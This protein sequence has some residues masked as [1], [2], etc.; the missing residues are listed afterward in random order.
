MKLISCYVENFGKLHE[1]RHT[2]GDG[3]NILLEDNGWGKTTFAA[4]LKAMFYGL[5]YTTKKSIAENERKHYMPWQGGNFGGYVIFEV[6]GRKYRVER[7]FGAKD[8]DDTFALYNEDSGLSCN[9]YSEH[10][11]EDLF[12]LDMEAFERS[13]YIPQQTS[14]TAINDSLAARLSNSSENSKEPESYQGAV[15]RLDE[16]I[17]YYKKKGDNGRISELEKSIADITHSLDQ[18]ENRTESVEQLKNRK[19]ELETKR[20][21]LFNELKE[22]RDDIKKASEYDGL[23]A[24]KSHY[25]ML[26]KNHL[27]SKSQFDACGLFFEKPELMEELNNKKDELD[28]VTELETKYRDESE[29]LK[30]LE[31]RKH[32]LTSQYAASRRTP[33]SSVILLL[34]GLLA[35]GGA[36]F[37]WV[38]NF[39]F[40]VAVGVATFGILLCV[41]GLVTWIVGGNRIKREFRGKIE[42]V[43]E[44]IDLSRITL[45]EI[46][47]NKERAQKNLENYL[48]GFQVEDPDNI[49]KSIA[50]IEAKIREYKRLKSMTDNANIELANFEAENDMDKI[51]G[52][53]VPKY[54]LGELQKREA[55]TNNALVSVMEEKNAVV[56]RMDALMNEDEDESDLLQAKENLEQQLQDA[57]QRYEILSMT[58]EFL[59]TA[60]ERFK[61]KYIQKMKKAFADYTGVL[62]GT[63]MEEASVDVDLNV[64]LEEFGTK[65]G[66]E[67]YSAGSQDMLS[68]AARFSLVEAMFEEE[69]PFLILD[70]P[71]VNLDGKRLENAMKFLGDIAKKYQILYFTCHDSRG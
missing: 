27:E 69:K 6:S 8:K 55:G 64:T 61:T 39:E 49:L 68:L 20:I 1:Y 12:G 30:E 15:D 53:A 58:K 48:R 34:L 43:D 22:I 18:Y 9:D 70:D 24:R 57:N 45:R 13:T 47:L 62:N 54:S 41:I 67:W 50:E 25:D 66:L 28:T 71:F 59:G 37:L 32:G 26:V 38:M 5:D 52:L 51:L 10:L 29:N 33:V 2:F 3:L 44:L 23:K 63:A 60:N 17:R 7:F 11:G 31:Y 14:K 65:H 40:L 35:V 42:E 36:V 4:F 16:K 46:K 56:R 19:N 21:E